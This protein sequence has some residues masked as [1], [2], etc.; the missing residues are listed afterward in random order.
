MHPLGLHVRRVIGLVSFQTAKIKGKIILFITVHR[1][2]AYFE[3]K[4]EFL[5]ESIYHIALRNVLASVPAKISSRMES[6]E[7]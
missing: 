3:R 6:E 1:T 4:Q 5:R 2:I 7:T